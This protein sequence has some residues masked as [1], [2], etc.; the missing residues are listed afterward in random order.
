MDKSLAEIL[1]LIG[2]DFN[3]LKKDMDNNYAKKVKNM[4]N[5][6]QSIAIDLHNMSD[7]DDKDK[8]VLNVANA[9]IALLN[10]YK[11]DKGDAK[12][13]S[14]QDVTRLRQAVNAI[15]QELRRF[16]S[17]LNDN[18]RVIEKCHKE[19]NGEDND[20][21]ESLSKEEL[22]ARLREKSK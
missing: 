1:E 2:V 7:Y 13:V 4:I 22:I 16:C 20:N 12:L 9:D 18:L 21:L 14:K 15:D 11:F 3:E 19:D 17:Y 8:T 10:A 5:E 6:A